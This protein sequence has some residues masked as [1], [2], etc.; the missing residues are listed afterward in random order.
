MIYSARLL[1]LSLL[2]WS[3]WTSPATV[4][5]TIFDTSPSYTVLANCSMQG[6]T[7]FPTLPPQTTMLDLSHNNLSDL[8]YYSLDMV[9]HNYGELTGLILQTT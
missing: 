1:R 7:I 2:L 6:P 5:S 4:T 3:T 9:K 8:S